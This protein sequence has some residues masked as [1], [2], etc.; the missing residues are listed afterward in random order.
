MMN[1]PETRIGFLPALST[2]MTAG[3]VAR[4]ILKEEQSVHCRKQRT[5]ATYTIPTTPVANKDTVFPV[6]PR[7]WKIEGA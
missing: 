3:I 7:F 6:R 2:Q 4:N 1:A 5:Y